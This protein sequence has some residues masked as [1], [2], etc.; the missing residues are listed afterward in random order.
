MSD[1]P[2]IKEI[3]VDMVQ[4][5]RALAAILKAVNAYDD[6]D[7]LAALIAVVAG[8]AVLT[9]AEPDFL[10]QKLDQAIAGIYEKCGGEPKVKR[11]AS[12]H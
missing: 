6:I 1:D 10:H 3:A 9:G 5:Q 12:I 2:G 11:N 4:S 7:A 8:F